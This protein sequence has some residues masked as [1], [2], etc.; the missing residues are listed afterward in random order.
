MKKVLF[1]FMVVALLAFFSGC[2]S[3]V[4][5][6]PDTGGGINTPNDQDTGG[7]GIKKASDPNVQRI[8]DE[9]KDAKAAYSARSVINLGSIA[10]TYRYARIDKYIDGYTGY[11]DHHPL[12]YRDWTGVGEGDIKLDYDGLNGDEWYLWIF[13]SIQG[14]DHYIIFANEDHADQFEIGVTDYPGQEGQVWFCRWE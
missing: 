2:S 10:T 11:P 4:N 12:E 9:L 7:A 5:S 14:G 6:D 3:P 13:I 1:V 8:Y